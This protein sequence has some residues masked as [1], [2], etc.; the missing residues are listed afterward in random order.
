MGPIRRHPLGQARRTLRASWLAL[1]C[2]LTLALAGCGEHASEGKDCPL[3]ER[4]RTSSGFCVPR[5]VSLKKGEVNARKGPGKDY[6]TIW[7]YHAKGLPVQVVAETEDWRRICDSQG[8][9]SWVSRAMVDG[10][11]TV[12][13]LGNTAMALRGKPLNTGPPAGAL[14]A[15][16]LASLDRCQGPWCKVKVGSVSGWAPAQSLWGVAP[17]A[18]CH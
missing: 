12:I 18:Q 9:A 13:V 6:P 16:T 15:Q 7:T 4:Q 14:N 8:V 11:R 1:G 2:A 17:S 10:R 3:A 5:W